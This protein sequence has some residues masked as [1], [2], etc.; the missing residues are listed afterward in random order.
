MSS[1]LLNT[2]LLRFIKLV[3]DVLHRVLSRE[4]A[5]TLASRR[6]PAHFDLGKRFENLRFGLLADV[7]L[8]LVLSAREL[9]VAH[10]LGI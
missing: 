8:S 5:L 9:L 10:H 3:D 1:V 4:L 7:A 2:V 6:G